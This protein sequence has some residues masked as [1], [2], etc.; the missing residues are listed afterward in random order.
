MVTYSK[1][2]LDLN[3]WSF[4]IFLEIGKDIGKPL[5]GPVGP[6]GETIGMFANIIFQSL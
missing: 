3:Y 2:C 1:F 6:S 5:P 4:C